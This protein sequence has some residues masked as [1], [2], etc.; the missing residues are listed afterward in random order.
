MCW[1]AAT[2]LTT[3]TYHASVELREALA[4]LPS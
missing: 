1:R 2:P 3:E 4:E